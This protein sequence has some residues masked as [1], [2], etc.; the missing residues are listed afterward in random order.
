[1]ACFLSLFRLF[2]GVSAESGISGT[3]YM[4]I[5]T[6]TATGLAHLAVIAYIPQAY[7]GTFPTNSV[8]GSSLSPL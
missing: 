3:L 1:M 6:F 4:F 2:Q 7:A 8:P 5:L